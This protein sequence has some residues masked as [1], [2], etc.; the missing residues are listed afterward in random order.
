MFFSPLASQATGGG[1]GG[2]EKE[3]KGGNGGDS[4]LDPSARRDPMPP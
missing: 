2:G 4:T 1:G 3:F